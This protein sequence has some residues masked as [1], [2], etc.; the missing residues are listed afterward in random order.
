MTTLKESLE[1]TIAR[2]AAA[3]LARHAREAGLPG[4][5]PD[6]AVALAGLM[7][8]RLVRPDATPEDVARVCAEA[9]ECHCATVCVNPTYVAAARSLLR[10]SGV[11]VCALVGYPLG[12]GTIAAKVFEARRALDDGARELEVVLPI[13]RLKGGEVHYVK[14]EL[15]EI[16][17]ACYQVAARCKIVIEPA[18]LSEEDRETACKIAEELN[19]DFVVASTGYGGYAASVDDVRWLRRRLRPGIGVKAVGTIE[20]LADARAMLDAGATR[21]GTSQALSIIEE[22]RGR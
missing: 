20:T 12:A 22:A 10:G 11:A 8:H 15:G 19:V 18:L 6:A 1:Q 3:T 17:S 13:G 14:E 7:D 5:S 21:L 9:L 2:V 16:V 4:A